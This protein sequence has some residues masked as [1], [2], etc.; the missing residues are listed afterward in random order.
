M[1]MKAKLS[2][3][4]G[5]QASAAP[6]AQ[7]EGTAELS[8]HGDVLRKDDVRRKKEEGMPMKAKL[9]GRTGS[10]AGAAPD[11]QAEEKPEVPGHEARCPD[12]GAKEP[13]ADAGW[14]LRVSL[15]E[16]VLTDADYDLEIPG[17]SSRE[18]SNRLAKLAVARRRELYERAE[19]ELPAERPNPL[20]RL[21]EDKTAKLF[22]WLRE[23]PYHDAVK[24]ML[25]EQGIAGVT[26]A[27]L[28]EFFQSEAN[29]HWQRRLSRA[30]TEANALVTYI[31]SHPVKFSA[32][33]LAA[34]GQ[35]AFRQIASGQVAPEAMTR[36]TNL[37][38]RAR[39]DERSDR[40]MEMRYEKLEL[41]RRSQTE[42]ALESF[43]AEIE[44][45]PEAREAFEAL[46]AEL[47]RAQEV[48]E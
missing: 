26:D 33:I 10:Q 36:L 24:A 21:A 35:E 25:A 11:A 31:E 13:A 12:A 44:K 15:S 34:L 4:T 42:A 40:L 5:S 41:E 29:A 23:C 3:R 17:E 39:A 7:A 9:S 19:A 14:G 46:R 22:N 1:P 43:A 37:F 48:A 30:A 6:N 32:G 16:P 2:G 45:H 18:R 38:L 20:F 8:G 28:E 47:A 27:E